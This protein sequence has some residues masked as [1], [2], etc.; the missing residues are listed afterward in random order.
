ML[1][2][3]DVGEAMF[4]P[5]DCVALRGSERAIAHGATDVGPTNPD[6]TVE[7]TLRVRPRNQPPSAPA[8]HSRMSREE[9]ES[10]YGA[11]DSDMRAVEDFARQHGLTMVS[12][13]PARRTI[14]LRGTVAQLSATFNVEL[15]QYEHPSGRFRGRTGAIFIPQDL[16]DVITG[17]FGLDDRPQAKA[18]F[19]IRRSGGV[20][21]SRATQA[22][23]T[24]TQVA[25]LYQF[26]TDA[27]GS[28]QCIGIIELG[29]GYRPADL[30]QYFSSIGI[31]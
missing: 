15:R 22:T 16:Q 6:Q 11:S 25:N 17:V 7:V 23:F 21:A 4:N 3:G 29:G 28:G 5:K 14:I 2:V 31:A 10:M 24:P 19:R 26:P 9:Y 8:A 27:D 18:H 20:A 12:S 13:D 30:T 1:F